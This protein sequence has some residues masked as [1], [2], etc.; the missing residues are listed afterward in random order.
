LGQPCLAA[1]HALLAPVAARLIRLTIR[2]ASTA[3]AALAALQRLALPRLAR[4]VLDQVVVDHT[5]GRLWIGDGKCT[6]GAVTAA[7][8]LATITLKGR[9]AGSRTAVAAAVTALAVGRP[10]PVGPDGRPAGL[11][12]QVDEG[13]LSDEELGEV[14]AAVAAVRRPGCVTLARPSW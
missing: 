10:Q 3:D 9:I 13:M 7:A 8:R 6:P 4:L 2:G 11:T 14:R 1:A 5:T 12:V